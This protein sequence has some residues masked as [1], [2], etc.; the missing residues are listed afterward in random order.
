MNTIKTFQ[1]ACAA[2]GVS[3]EAVPDFSA[4]PEDHRKS[5]EAFYKLRIIAQAL[6]EGWKPDWSNYDQYKW[7]PWFDEKEAGS[8]L[9]FDGADLWHAATFVG[10]RLCF[11]SKE[12]CRYA[13]EQ[14][15]DLYSDLMNN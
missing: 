7:F 2:I 10:S 9:S 14:F 5:L 1:D 3:P 4:M 13:A 6:N 15:A 12:L 11:K 8:G